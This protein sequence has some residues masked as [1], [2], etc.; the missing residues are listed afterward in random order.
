MADATH[1]ELLRPLGQGGFGTVW[2]ATLRGRDG[3]S[4]RV[5]VKVMRDAPS[6]PAEIIARQR[7]EARL[8]GLLQHPNI[9]Q[10]LDLTEVDGAPAVVMEHVEGVDIATLL[11][12]YGALPESCVVAVGSA[13]AAALDAGWNATS[14]ETGRTLR[15]IHRDIKPANV[16]VT[17]HG[18]VKVLDFGVARADFDREGRTQSMAFGT[19]RFM[20]PEQFLTGEVTPGND[21][22]A[23]AVTMWEMLV[24]RS[25]ERPPL[26]EEAFLSKVEAQLPAVPAD[27]RPLIRG[28]MA[29]STRSRPTAGEVAAA[30]DDMKC[31]GDTLRTW[32]RRSV[33]QAMAAQAAAGNRVTTHPSTTPPVPPTT[34]PTPATP[35]V[36]TPAAAPAYGSASPVVSGST[37]AYGSASPMV[38]GSTPAYGSAGPTVSGSTPALASASPTGEVAAAE[39][40]GLRGPAAVRALAPPAATNSPSLDPDSSL[41]SPR[42]TASTSGSGKLAVG[43]AGAVAG[44]ALVAGF[45]MLAAGL[46]WWNTQPMDDGASADAEISAPPPESAGASPQDQGSTPI[47]AGTNPQ[48]GI[49]APVSPSVATPTTGTSPTG[50]RKLPASPVKVGEK[51]AGPETIPVT[52][53]LPTEPKTEVPTPIPTPVPEIAPPPVAVISPE[54]PVA[55]APVP[56]KSLNFRADSVGW[57]VY[58]DGKF[59]GTT[60][61]LRA[62]VPYGNHQVRMV[63]DGNSAQKSFEVSTTT[64]GTLIYTSGTNMWTWQQ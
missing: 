12:L 18:T 4:R 5:A 50:S 46:W 6:Q 8:L 33:P 40:P 26:S 23:L 34:T 41:A 29:W 20:A 15:V 59:I 48:P 53:T 38:S 30:L 3:F 11:K 35:S 57:T 27:F 16:L 31:P 24:G 32:A 10:V 49:A 56:T 9:V 52:P 19:P 63:L 58:L 54:P 39:T 61:L 17:L 13:I 45:S 28:M 62:I 47:E 51:A 37:P 55:A 36:S 25:W 64:A 21:V 7:D 43:A 1:L 14:P 2:L 44:M 60:P 42:A 22:Y